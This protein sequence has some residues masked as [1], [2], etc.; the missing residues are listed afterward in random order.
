[1][2]REF[3]WAVDE[4]GKP[5][6]CYA[7]PENRGKRNCNHKF[8]AKPGQD[9]KEFLAEHSIKIKE[10]VT[11]K[12]NEEMSQDEINSFASK[13][14]EI[15]GEKV[16]EENFEEVLNKLTPEQLDQVSKLGFEAAPAFSLPIT[17]EAYNEVNLSN[18]IYFAELPDYHIGGKKNAIENMFG[19][20]GQVPI[21]SETSVNIEGNYRD[22]LSS[23]E[24]FNK[25]FSTRGSQIQKVIAVS[26]PGRT[27]RLLF[28]GLA[29]MQVIKDCGN[30]DSDGI[31]HCHAPGGVCEKCAKKSG[32]NV[33][34]GQLAGGI[35]STQLSEGLTQ[36]SLSAIHTGGEHKEDWEVISATLNS[37]VSSPVIQE[38]KK[39]ETTEEA[40]ETIFKGLKGL[41]KKAGISI[42]DYNLQV[43]AKKLTSYKNRNGHLSYV[44]EDE[45]CDLPSL[46]TI[47]GHDNLFLQSELRNSYKKI[48]K[49]MEFTNERNA[50]T[51][52]MG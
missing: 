39:K 8:H 28:Y 9:A 22:G 11:F 46:Q 5:C 47:G 6:K 52:I 25:M 35:I 31:M 49:P 19:S 43:I 4:D 26:K 15:C 17:D 38:A 36:S 37:S 50:V 23:E 41:Y 32:W 48:S 29:D 40:R 51:A 18:K 7:K 20:I 1:M 27:Q 42:D 12:E 33:K 16:T 30:K 44:K 13:L 34:E 45:L 21:T 3:V 2:A 10:D 24:Y 14:D